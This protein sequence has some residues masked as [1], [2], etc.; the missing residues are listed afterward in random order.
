[1]GAIPT[2]YSKDRPLRTMTRSARF[3]KIAS[4]AAGIYLANNSLPNQI[5]LS[6]CFFDDPNKFVS[7]RSLKS[8]IASRYLEVRVANAGLNDSNKSLAIGR[9][10]FDIRNRQFAALEP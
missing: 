5:R 8:R 9:W 7:K 3:T 6:S 1:M 4:S 10:A 2:V